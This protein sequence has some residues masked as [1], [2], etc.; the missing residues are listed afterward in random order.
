MHLVSPLSFIVMIY[1][2]Q[3]RNDYYQADNGQDV[4][5]NV[6]HFFTEAITEGRQAD[7]PKNTAK[8]VI[9]K[10]MAVIHLAD[11]GDD[12]YQRP[13]GWYEARQDQSLA[14]L[15]LEKVMGLA[16]PFS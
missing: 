14:A 7:S 12:G 3:N 4:L 6:G 10:K 1:H 13:Y 5:I 8:G 11:A 15:R 9:C 2:R 16:D